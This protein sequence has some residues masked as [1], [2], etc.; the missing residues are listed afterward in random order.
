MNSAMRP[1]PA[2]LLLLFLASLT[3]VQII[4]AQGASS[5]GDCP[6]CS[7][8]NGRPQAQLTPIMDNSARTLGINA[9]YEDLS[10]GSRPP[11]SDAVLILQV[12]PDPSA[13]R[14]DQLYAFYT[15][16]NGR[17]SYDFNRAYLDVQNNPD[18]EMADKCVHFKV[19]YCP[20]CVPETPTCGFMA[21]MEYARIGA[22]KSKYSNIGGVGTIER[23]SDIPSAGEPPGALNEEKYLP[24]VAFAD[25]CPPPPALGATPALC[26]PLIII[27]SLLSGALYVS[28][29]NPF[30]AFNLGGGRLGRHIRYQAR[31]RGVF[32]SAESVA[33]AGQSVKSASTTLQKG[34][35]G[36][37]AKQEGAAA[38]G[39]V[40]LVGTIAQATAGMKAH[41]SG[42][43][44][45][46]DAVQKARDEK[47]AELTGMKAGDIAKMSK[48]DK[49]RL[50]RTHQKE[51]D[52][53][54]KAAGE[55]V[56]ARHMEAILSGTGGAAG[57]SKEALTGK[58]SI[59]VPGSMGGQVRGSELAYKS[60]LGGVKGF[61]ATLGGQLAKTGLFLL[62]NSRAVQFV[63]AFRYFFTPQDNYRSFV[64]M[65][66]V[67]NTQRLQ[68]DLQAL[69]EMAGA[70]GSAIRLP[71]GT[72]ATLAKMEVTRDAKGKVVETRI[73][74]LVDKEKSCTEDGLLTVTIGKGGRIESVSCVA[75]DGRVIGLVANPEA[76]EAP[77]LTINRVSQGRQPAP[78][79]TE[80]EK[81]AWAKA[82]EPI[83]SALGFV[84]PAFALDALQGNSSKNLIAEC[85]RSIEAVS[86]INKS[87]GE[88]RGNV[89][90]DLERDVSRKYPPAQQKEMLIKEH[91]RV[92][93]ETLFLAL[94]RAPSAEEFRSLKASPLRDAG[95]LG[96]T[97]A[98]EV[99]FNKDHG[100]TQQKSAAVGSAIG[101]V[102]AGKSAAE[103]SALAKDPKQ[104]TSLLLPALQKQ[105]QGVVSRDEARNMLSESTV[106]RIGSAIGDA[107]D[108]HN[109]APL[110]AVGNIVAHSAFSDL[111]AFGTKLSK[112]GHIQK[113]ETVAAVLDGLVS[114]STLSELESMKDP[115]RLKDGM[116]RAAVEYMAIRFAAAGTA[117]EEAR[118]AGEYTVQQVSSLDLTKDPFAGGRVQPAAREALSAVVL[119]FR[120][121]GMGEED[122]Q[123][124]AY[125]LIR[126]MSGPAMASMAGPISNAAHAA[127]TQF[128]KAGFTDTQASEFKNIDVSQLH[129]IAWARN[130]VSA[131]DAPSRAS[132]FAELL[133]RNPSDASITPEVRSLLQQ[134]EHYINM[135]GNSGAV[136]QA[137]T[138]GGKNFVNLASV[139]KR[140]GV[141]TMEY[142]HVP[143]AAMAQLAATDAA[144]RK[145]D[146]PRESAILPQKLPAMP[147]HKEGESM[148][149][150]PL[151]T[152]TAAGDL[153]QAAALQSHASRTERLM[154]WNPNASYEE[155]LSSLGK[156][157]RIK[158]TVL[159]VSL[160]NGDLSTA[161][162]VCAERVRYYREV[163]DASSMDAWNK[164]LED[165]AGVRRE[166]V[167]P[168]TSMLGSVI[169][170]NFVK[171]TAPLVLEHEQYQRT[172][173][174]D[175]LKKGEL[176]GA[177]EIASR[178]SG[179][180]HL[181]GDDR[182]ADAWGAMVKHLDGLKHDG[183]SSELLAA[184]E[185]TIMKRFTE[186]IQ[187]PEEIAKNEAVSAHSAAAS[188]IDYVEAQKATAE[189]HLDRAEEG[190]KSIFSTTPPP[191]PI[192]LE[193][194]KRGKGGGGEEPPSEPGEPPPS[195]PLAGEKS[196]TPGTSERRVEPTSQPESRARG[197]E[198][199]QPVSSRLSEASRHKIAFATQEEAEAK[200]KRENAAKKAS[201]KKTA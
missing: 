129:D 20:F 179:Y 42:L 60:A 86:A 191:Q 90:R 97:I 22:D 110:V 150:V 192:E 166:G 91:G 159:N 186:S 38:K 171:T 81:L 5:A 128:R 85:K 47:L 163:G 152:A 105:G 139:S 154:G 77:I 9:F 141:V 11:I 184:F 134:R 107:V 145:Y 113:T 14:L 39:R 112:A 61:L 52:R 94:G 48:A 1:L 119:Q 196:G 10:T 182:T 195:K 120:S 106:I 201:D 78:G 25:Y 187:K 83:T 127:G 160:S 153:Q 144:F 16:G 185:P 35:L 148:A 136:E 55:G 84:S 31:G 142:G 198:E 24:Q 194:K 30:T 58:G 4:A 114:H 51:V 111:P 93:T 193:P 197:Q 101:A 172:A 183:T 17:A 67:R 26:L 3:A 44:A 124:E 100:F 147:G 7:E 65:A 123:R 53:A 63:E 66:F 199:G 59:F 13:G 175:N 102:L 21:C 71:D 180:Y 74:L 18:P 143:D 151:T 190:I 155:N 92:A 76:A 135:Q 43:A 88:D 64:E 149:P 70:G 138:E 162:T 181:A 137:L 12:S 6:L 68:N 40:F 189:Y 104:L 57:G 36:A 133:A 33:A 19:V 15:D 72:A 177:R 146:T 157:E 200:Y 173:F 140:I 62:L 116:K 41:K 170:E 50:L 169:L 99:G 29:R 89:L 49:D 158:R 32:T 37:L 126:S 117:P 122:A 176:D 96:R 54:G 98:D 125:T 2:V 69:K 79:K 109:K 45:R 167:S 46:A 23:V 73:S 168:G 174:D 27:F 103:I 108:S 131:P 8:L 75:A 82:A 178:Q 80:P 56:V 95:A 164:A 115:A 130:A 118:K 28:G 132:Q 156:D 34:G 121:T 87:C 165:A 161:Q 188:N